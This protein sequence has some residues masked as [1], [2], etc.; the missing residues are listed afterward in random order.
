[1]LYQLSLTTKLGAASYNFLYKLVQDSPELSRTALFRK[2]QKRE[3]PLAPDC[4][5]PASVNSPFPAVGMAHPAP[6]PTNTITEALPSITTSDDLSFDLDYFLANNPFGEL[7]NAA[8]LDMGGMEQ[9]W[10][11]EN[12]HLDGI[13]QNGSTA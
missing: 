7:D 2:R 11:W 13:S 9:I 4:D 1:M 8:P 10:D 5:L 3:T 6:V 12:L